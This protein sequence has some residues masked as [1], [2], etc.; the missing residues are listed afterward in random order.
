MIN[1]LCPISGIA[2]KCLLE[3]NLP[4]L[5]AWHFQHF[6]NIIPESPEVIA[7]G[8]NSFDLVGTPGG[9]C[10][11]MMVTVTPPGR[12]FTE[13]EARVDTGTVPDLQVILTHVLLSGECGS[14]CSLCGMSVTLFPG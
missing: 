14:C 7:T 3:G 11:S 4:D 9:P 6:Q 1:G 5:F 12:D 2:C 13:I 8:L 10:I